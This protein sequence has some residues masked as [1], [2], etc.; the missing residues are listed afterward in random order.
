MHSNFWE[1]SK[2]T[3]IVHTLYHGQTEHIRDHALHGQSC[4]DLSIL[5]QRTIHRHEKSETMHSSHVWQGTLFRSISGSYCI[6][7]DNIKTVLSNPVSTWSCLNPEQ[8][9]ILGVMHFYHNWLSMTGGRHNLRHGSPKTEH[10]NNA[11]IDKYYG[12]TN[13][14]AWNWLWQ[15]W[16]STMPRW[17][18]KP[19]WQYRRLCSSIMTKSEQVC[20]EDCLQVWPKEDYAFQPCLDPK[21]M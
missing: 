1:S 12:Q 8:D 18:S 20:T 10:S 7:S 13:H 4:L 17:L 16:G 19:E 15:W 2:N 21:S 9:G 14:Q 5:G 3:K 6:I 11:W